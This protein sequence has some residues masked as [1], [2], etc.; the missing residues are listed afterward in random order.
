MFRLS[1]LSV[2]QFAYGTIHAI[3]VSLRCRLP[4]SVFLAMLKW[5][6]ELRSRIGARKKKQCRSQRADGLWENCVFLYQTKN[7][8]P[9]CKKSSF[10]LCS[11]WKFQLAHQNQRTASSWGNCDAGCAKP[12]LISG[13]AAN[14]AAHYVIG[15]SLAP[16]WMADL[17]CPALKPGHL[18]GSAK[19]HDLELRFGTFPSSHKAKSSAR[20]SRLPHLANKS[21]F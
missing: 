19:R 14:D 6:S 21:R 1:V 7:S 16:I 18:P 13:T 20:N 11:N 8:K 10:L 2:V 17:K 3:G 4:L 12:A 9:N 5:R 15:G